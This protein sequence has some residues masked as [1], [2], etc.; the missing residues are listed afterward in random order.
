MDATIGAVSEILEGSL[1]S[2]RQVIAG[3]TPESLNWRPAGEDTNTIAMLVVHAMQST[4]W[5]LSIATGAPPP[6]RDRPAEFREVVDDV[7]ELLARFDEMAADCRKILDT[8]VPFEAGAA[9]VAPSASRAGRSQP[10]ETVTAAWALV[11]AV[12]H[13]REHVAH[14]ELTSQL[15]PRA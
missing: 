5:W 4:R 12:E 7:D 2:M 11:H 6:P 13:L 10:S 8:D 9:R 15:F 1:A 14:A 3:S